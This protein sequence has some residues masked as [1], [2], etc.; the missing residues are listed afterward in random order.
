LAELLKRSR[1][2]SA[3]QFGEAGTME[4]S[5]G[6]TAI[7]RFRPST[8][9]STAIFA[10]IIGI[11]VS[12]QAFPAAAEDTPGPGVPTASSKGP[13]KF[14]NRLIESNDP[15]LLLHAHNPVD[16]YPWGPEAF[17]KAKKENKPI[18]LSIGYSTC[19]W[20]HVAERTIYSNP[21]IAKLMNQWF[22]NVKVD[23][24]Q[25]PDVDRIYV[26]ARQLMAGSGGWPNN[27]FLTP[28][29]KPFYAGSYFP[30]RDDPRAGPGFPTVLAAIHQVWTSDRTQALSVAENVMATMRRVQSAM[31]GSAVAPI[32]PDA[33]L[34]KARDTLSPQLDPQY[35]GFADRRSGTKF[36]NPPR[37]A[38]LLLDYQINSTPAALSGVLNTLDAMVLGGIHD[39][40][41]GGFHRYS[42]EP[43]WSVPHFEKMLYD[44][45][46]LL[47][48]YAEAFRI[49]R[50]PLYR[51]TAV[52][53]ARYLEKDAMAPEG[54]FYTARDAQLHGVEGEG[55]L[56]TRGEIASLLGDKEATR[57]LGVYA[58][59]PVPRPNVP[60]VVHPPDV[61]GEPPAVL[62]LRVPVDLTLK[63]AGFKDVPQ[64]LAEFATDRAKLMAAREK[65]QQPAR[66]E[67]I[68]VSLNGLTIAALAESGQILD[69]PQLVNWAQKAAE[70]IWALAYD[71]STGV[72]KHEIYRGQVQTSG[73]L[74]DYASLG[75]AF[76]S[77]ADVTGTKTWRDR[78]ALLANSLLD[79]FARE[80][81]SFSTTANEQDLLIPIADDADMETPSGTSMA[82]DLLLRLHEASGE[83]RYLDTATRAVNRLSGQFQERPEG[84]AAAV[85]ALNRRPLAST[86]ENATA[87]NSPP[88]ASTPGGIRMPVTADH[89]RVAASGKSVPDGDEIL[90]TIKV[91]DKF[92]I[93]ANPASFDFLI[94]TSVEF[95]GVKPAKVEY[96]KPIRFTAQFAP[97]GL[98][99]YEGS[100]AVVAKFPKGSLR[101]IKAI[102]GSVTA[103]ACT[104]QIC[105]PPSTLPISIAVGDR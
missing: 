87:A 80:D 1:K 30:P 63:M 103:Q 93:N 70:R 64:M 27:L 46:Q 18:F 75:V 12:L 40:L 100:I 54:G 97:E 84:W 72:L 16:W 88:V 7:R 102:Q 98:D 31:T 90:V 57:F 49:T 73:F 59:T 21:D 45:A 65:R 4:R 58:L 60:D 105:L 66:D 91:D 95:K 104:N 32:K 51:E 56:W 85:A 10:V 50:N 6:V 20:C 83:A 69:E 101:G 62:R 48:L 33:W 36:P 24:E 96:P 3:A 52:E 38:L 67:K 15:Y 94:P 35:G 41:A 39:H 44:N 9:R 11:A 77:L 22:V 8:R 19:Y 47:R 74:Q 29:L 5:H 23:S 55:Y 78:A 89:V 82:V 61:N 81:G 13:Y 92:H 14:T 79:R 25:R 28:D 34:A 17:A 26:L 71:Q 99:V 86:H 42:T 43:T 76:M 37:L 2:I 53:T 68:V